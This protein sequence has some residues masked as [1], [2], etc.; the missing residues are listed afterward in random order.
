MKQDFYN[1]ITRNIS[2]ILYGSDKS[3]IRNKKINVVVVSSLFLV[4]QLENF[5]HR[6]LQMTCKM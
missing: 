5:L 1:H 4:M 6:H 2:N 3:I